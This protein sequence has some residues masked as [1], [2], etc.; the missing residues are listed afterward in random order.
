M[1]NAVD[2][3]RRA[4]RL[5]RWYPTAWN[6]RY[7]DEF[8][9][10]LEQEFAER[11]VDLKR[12]L[13][14]ACRGLVA[15]VGDFGLTSSDLK[16]EG[17]SRA[18][19]GT[20]FTLVAIAS[21]LTLNFWSLSVGRWSS[22]RFHPLPDTI[23]TGI[24]TVT[25]GLLLLVLMAIV[26]AVAVS[27]ARQIRR[28]RARPLVGP[29]LLAVGSGAFI[30]YAARWLPMELVQYT[31]SPHGRP[32]IQWS[33][34]GRTIAALA[35]STWDLTQTWVSLWT[36]RMY[37]VPTSQ[38]IVN[39]LLPIALLVLGIAIA[40]LLRRVELP[41][42][43]ERVGSA[44][45]ALLGV[46]LGTFLVAFFVWFTVG[47]PSGSTVFVTEGPSAGKAYLIFLVLVA[48]L[49]G[50]SGV[51]LARRNHLLGRLSISD[52]SGYVA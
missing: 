32:G 49:V 51:R 16:F 45:V 6:E 28:K 2:Y 8:V 40:V 27:S 3:K 18:T 29:S 30:L 46:L 22:R 42:I 48:V 34:P 21:V 52:S 4:T 25:A 31:H 35:Q 5:L 41:L 10:H 23:A 20:S 50:R 44:V 37:G 38:I 7:G 11:P 36:Q 15:R 19:I 33:H 43:G 47:G 39:D 14:I 17:E 1:S 26:L 13:N 9:D 24:L 12:T